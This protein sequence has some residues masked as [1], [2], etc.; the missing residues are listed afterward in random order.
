MAGLAYAADHECQRPRARYVRFGATIW[1]A[2]VF[3]AFATP[4]SVRASAT[5]PTGIAIES[6]KVLDGVWKCGEHIVGGRNLIMTV[7]I[8]P[9]NEV[10][11]FR[12]SLQDTR[13]SNGKPWREELYWSYSLIGH[14]WEMYVFAG[15][16]RGE[17]D[18][19]WWQGNTF[20]WHGSM[21]DMLVGHIHNQEIVWTRH[22]ESHL[23]WNEDEPLADGS[24][25]LNS[26]ATCV[27]SLH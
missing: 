14:A 21:N 22:G 23:D 11:W 25:V 20:T 24:R 1:I 5:G 10:N 15:Y 18:G 4:A 19:W 27:R 13:G 26:S 8:A 3:P 6:M 17:F 9:A 2:V 16:E 12:S 7:S